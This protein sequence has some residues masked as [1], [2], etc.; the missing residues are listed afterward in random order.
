MPY[1]V[2]DCLS[3]LARSPVPPTLDTLEAG[4][5]ATIADTMRGDAN[6]RAVGIWSV[7]A[8]LAVG[9]VGGAT[10]ASGLAPAQ[11]SA[12]AARIIGVDTPLAPSTLLLGR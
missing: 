11:A 3:R 7:T 1:D 2:D 8:A 4:V 12:Q 10:L 5:F 6:G 9:L